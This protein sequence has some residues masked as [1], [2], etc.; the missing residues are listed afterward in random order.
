MLPVR[1]QTNFNVTSIII[2]PFALEG[3]D[4][5]IKCTSTTTLDFQCHINAT[6]TSQEIH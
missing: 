2:S 6:A 3:Y 4:N 5:G 1:P